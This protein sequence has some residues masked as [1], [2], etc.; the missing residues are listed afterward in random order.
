MPTVYFNIV[1][2]DEL[3][4]EGIKIPWRMKLLEEF[5]QVQEYSCHYR[6]ELKLFRCQNAA[7]EA[8]IISPMYCLRD[9]RG[10]EREK[11]KVV[12]SL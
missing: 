1:T 8:A 3:R 12:G 9:T 6:C 11:K 5:I 7:G 10:V 4:R 2:R